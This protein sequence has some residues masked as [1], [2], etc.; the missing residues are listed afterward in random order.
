MN[1]EDI[2][3]LPVFDVPQTEPPTPVSYEAA[4]T[5]FEELARGM[6]IREEPPTGEDIPLFE[7]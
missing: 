6:R 5:A 2:F 1:T 7:L 4:M 3:E